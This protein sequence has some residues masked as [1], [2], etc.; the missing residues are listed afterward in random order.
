MVFDS[1]EVPVVRGRGDGV[2]RRAVVRVE[3]ESSPC[4]RTCTNRCRTRGR[5]Q[6]DFDDGSPRTG[7]VPGAL[8]GGERRGGKA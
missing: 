5:S 3:A 2:H 4:A 1:A 8:E 6:G 7:G